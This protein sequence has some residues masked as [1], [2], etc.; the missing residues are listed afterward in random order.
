M[1]RILLSTM[2]GSIKKFRDKSEYSYPIHYCYDT[3]TAIY[4][5]WHKLHKQSLNAVPDCKFIT[6]DI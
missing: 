2:C 6:A 3:L 4:Q 1:Y 5:L